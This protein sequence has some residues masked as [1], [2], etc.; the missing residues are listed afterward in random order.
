MINGNPAAGSVLA[1]TKEPV[2]PG[3]AFGTL[4]QGLLI[5]TAS[6]PIMAGELS[7][8]TSPRRM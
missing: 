1:L 5:L 3:P 6:T 8:V 7:P 4:S 2:A